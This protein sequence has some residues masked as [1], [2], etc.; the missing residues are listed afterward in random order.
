MIDVRFGAKWKKC[1]CCWCFFSSLYYESDSFFLFSCFFSLFVL[2]LLTLHAGFFFTKSF[3]GNL[4]TASSSE[5]KLN[6]RFKRNWIVRRYLLIWLFLFSFC[7]SFLH[8]TTWNCFVCVWMHRSDSEKKT[9]REEELLQPVSMEN[10]M[11]NC[12][13][14]KAWQTHHEFHAAKTENSS[15]HPNGN[16]YFDWK[17]TQA[18]CIFAII[19]I[20]I[21]HHS[22]EYRK[23]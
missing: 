19:N 18:W 9:L 3:N 5:L 7:F 6:F 12:R 20:S 22:F 4:I 16:M 2:V 10:E 17:P 23:I 13:L 15:D 1:W 8:W 11:K 14:L 21:H